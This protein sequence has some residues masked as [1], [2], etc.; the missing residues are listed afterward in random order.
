MAKGISKEQ[1]LHRMDY[2][3]KFYEIKEKQYTDAIAKIDLMI[4]YV[5]K[6]KK[7]KISYSKLL[8]KFKLGAF[9]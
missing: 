5:K 8:K 2:I 9:K 3:R 4:A 1:I 7:L 6:Q